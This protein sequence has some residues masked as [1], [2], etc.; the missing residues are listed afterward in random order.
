M[1]YYIIIII[2]MVLG[3]PTMNQGAQ[4]EQV[5]IND[6]VDTI[7]K[8]Y[9]DNYPKEAKLELWKA[10]DGSY[11]DYPLIGIEHDEPDA[12]QQ[13]LTEGRMHSPAI[14]E[15]LKNP[16]RNQAVVSTHNPDLIMNEG[17]K[18]YLKNRYKRNHHG[19]ILPPDYFDKEEMEKQTP[20]AFFNNFKASVQEKP[21]AYLD[22][23]ENPNSLKNRFKSWFQ[24]LQKRANQLSAAQFSIAAAALT[25]L[26]AL[27]NKET[28]MNWLNNFF[29]KLGMG[30]NVQ[31]TQINQ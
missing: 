1:K 16:R 20:E 28:I 25:T 23:L 26:F 14:K 9:K 2:A 6:P 22:R 13:I 31:S 15:L 24:P 17:L 18:I 11:Q 30:I 8:K 29:S 3:L 12:L 27:Y 7:I 10:I 19:A 4:K 21:I 5:E